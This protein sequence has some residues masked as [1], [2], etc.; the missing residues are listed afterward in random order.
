MGRIERYIQGALLPGT[1]HTLH[2]GRDIYLKRDVFL[3]TANY[4]SDE[5]A[6][7]ALGR[8]AA[9]S[10]YRNDRF[11]HILDVFRNGLQLCV[12][13]KAERGGQLTGALAERK[14]LQ[15]WLSSLLGLGKAMLDAWEAGI[16]GYSVS[17]D[18]LWVCPDGRWMIMNYWDQAEAKFQGAAGLSVLSLQH[19]AGS[20]DLPG[21]LEDMEP[22][23]RLYLQS[24]GLSEGKTSQML[25]ILKQSMVGTESLSSFLFA[26]QET[27]FPELKLSEGTQPQQAKQ[28]EEAADP[29]PQRRIAEAG[30]KPPARKQVS[31]EPQ[32]A[33]DGTGLRRL[34]L[35]ALG[36]LC[37]LIVAA[38]WVKQ[39]YTPD[40]ASSI[41]AAAPEQKQTAGGE[42]GAR[43]ADEKN[44]PTQPAQQSA[45]SS[46]GTSQGEGTA[47]QTGQGQAATETEQEAEEE[48]AVP[49]IAEGESF[50]AP[51]LVGLTREAAEKLALA[52]GL[53]YQFYLV[54]NE[55]PA[56]EVFE[57][58][59][60]AGTTSKRGDAILFW[61]SR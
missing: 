32:E 55:A 19:M 9:A 26:V 42:A 23:L 38:V 57:Q 20:A 17:I 44:E 29:V 14:P 11:M 24:R 30:T 33:S 43:G 7:R 15:S 12:V 4:E 54:D 22:V 2:A 36:S 53:K 50:P 16:Q 60:A 52:H 47:E 3:Y 18:N 5:E 31:R 25:R 28:T 41:E 27:V 35:I 10:S 39:A 13:L 40:A 45:P 34:L 46:P 59:P 49:V 37:V 58:E 6:E 48:P 21:R 61:V 8:I 51:A 1:N 56:G